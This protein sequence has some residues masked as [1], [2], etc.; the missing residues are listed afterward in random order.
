MLA[1]PHSPSTPLES[2]DAV[3]IAA[4]ATPSAPVGVTAGSGFENGQAVIVA[5]TDYG[6]DPVRGSLVGLSPERIS[7][8]RDDP[9]AGRVH[10]HFP[11]HG[12]QL[13]KDKGQPA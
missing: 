10:V 12:F 5:A 9:R 13:R 11:R 6:T 4:A 1:I 2:A 3:A 7:I 8:A